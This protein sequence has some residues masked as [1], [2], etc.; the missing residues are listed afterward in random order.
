M[1][2][3]SWVVRIRSLVIVASLV[4][5]T[6]LAQTAVLS[7]SAPADP[8]AKQ[9]WER[10]LD[11]ELRAIG[12]VGGVALAVIDV[13]DEPVLVKVRTRLANATVLEI[14]PDKA[15]VVLA[16][17]GKVNPVLPVVRAL[18]VAF[19]V[20][21]E[22]EIEALLSPAS[23]KDM[24]RTTFSLAP[25]LEKNWPTMR[26]DKKEA[27]LLQHLKE[28]LLMSYVTTPSG[29]AGSI[30]PLFAE[31]AVQRKR[32]RLAAFTASLTPEQRKIFAGT[33]APVFSVNDLGGDPQAVKVKMATAKV[34]NDRALE[35]LRATLSAEQK[36]LYDDA[37]L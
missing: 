37:G 10:N 29:V 36:K 14:S 21:T 27:V 25:E 33:D 23:L 17:P 34:K 3:H 19:P 32:E 16:V 5:T 22:A 31:L 24:E 18:T 6:A 11:F 26:R 15:Q 13:N 12:E 30:G 8:A 4:T 2:F 28:G 9:E 20:L 7:S 35:N 1:V